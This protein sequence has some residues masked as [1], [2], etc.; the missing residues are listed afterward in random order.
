MIII[1]EY[2]YLKNLDCYHKFP[3]FHKNQDQY[4]TTNG[5]LIN[6]TFLKISFPFA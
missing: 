3:G 5:I 4:Y 6:I 2:S 1:I